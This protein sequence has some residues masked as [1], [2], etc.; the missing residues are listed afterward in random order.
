LAG[1]LMA[2]GALALAPAAWA[3]G[4]WSF[5]SSDHKSIQINWQTDNGQD[6]QFEVFTLTQPVQSAQC[7]PAI[8]VWSVSLTAARISSSVT[9]ENCYPERAVRPA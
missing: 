1:S 9:A 8:P 5:S 3:S 7:G 2:V 4:T 6:A